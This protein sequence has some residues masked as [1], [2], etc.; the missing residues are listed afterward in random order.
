MSIDDFSRLKLGEYELTDGLYNYKL[1]IDLT[2]DGHRIYSIKS[3]D[4]LGS[5]YFNIHES[6]DK[7]SGKKKVIYSAKIGAIFIHSTD[8]PD[9]ISKLKIVTPSK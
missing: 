2:T 3:K 4:A 8:R 6:T 9:N 5:S 1:I 7:H